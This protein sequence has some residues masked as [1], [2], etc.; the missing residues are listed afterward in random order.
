MKQWISIVIVVLCFCPV[1]GGATDMP[2]ITVA[3]GE[4]FP[5]VSNSMDD[6][7]FAAEVV[8]YAFLA[9]GI[10]ATIEHHT[11][12]DGERLIKAGRVAAAF[13][14]AF[15]KARKGYALFSAPIAQSKG[16]FF[17]KKERFPN[18]DVTRLKTLRNKTLA[19]VTGAF[20]REMFAEAGLKV[21]YSRSAATAFKRLYI[22]GVDLVPENEFVGWAL[23]ERLYPDELYKFAAAKTPFH[24]STLHL[25]V[26]RKTP[27]ARR[28]LDKFNSGLASIRRQGLYQRLLLKYIRTVSIQMPKSPY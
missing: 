22:D 18:F 3:T 2:T 9:A 17:Y 14:H 16:V 20:Y 7:G 23:L 27:G 8:F 15:T 10:E 12:D 13:P 25:M 5:Y 19:G 6:G 21:V 4:W 26:S 28:L 24:A 1:T 11:W